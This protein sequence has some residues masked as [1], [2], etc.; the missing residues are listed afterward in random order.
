[1]TTLRHVVAFPLIALV[2]AFW[3]A[4]TGLAKLSSATGTVAA[5]VMGPRKR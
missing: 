4:G 3:A 1:M 5:R 2:L